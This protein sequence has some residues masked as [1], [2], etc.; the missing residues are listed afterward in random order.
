MYKTLVE[1]VFL[2]FFFFL[3][4]KVVKMLHYDIFFR[5]IQVIIIH[6]IIEIEH[7]DGRS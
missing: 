3:L 4:P 1:L 5:I 2:S 7:M 6:E